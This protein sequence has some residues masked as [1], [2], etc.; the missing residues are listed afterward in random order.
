MILRY[1]KRE[2][3]E[4]NLYLSENW[5]SRNEMWCAAGNHSRMR[6]TCAKGFLDSNFD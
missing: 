1:K 2:I 6:H 5:L 3:G 4:G